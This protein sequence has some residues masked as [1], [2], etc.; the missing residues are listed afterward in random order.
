M[1]FLT[2][3]GKSVKL[4]I[5]GIRGGP[6]GNLSGLDEYLY[7][8]HTKITHKPISSSNILQLIT[9]CSARLKIYLTIELVHATLNFIYHSCVH[10][11]IISHTCLKRS[12]RLDVCVYHRDMDE[13]ELDELSKEL[14]QFSSP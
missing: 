11:E 1:P 3:F 7:S 5:I 12:E 9:K 13:P 8:K 10:Y 6:G 2:S 14:G 4:P